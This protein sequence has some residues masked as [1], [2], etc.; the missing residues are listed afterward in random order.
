MLTP[1]VFEAKTKLIIEGLS[2]RKAW[3]LGYLSAGMTWILLTDRG[4]V[5]WTVTTPDPTTI[6]ALPEGVIVH[7]G[8]LRPIRFD[9]ESGSVPQ[10]APQQALMINGIPTLLFSDELWVAPNETDGR[11]GTWERSPVSEY[12]SRATSAVW[13]DGAEGNGDVWISHEGGISQWN[14]NEQTWRTPEALSRLVNSV[15]SKGPWPSGVGVW[16][17]Q[18]HLVQETDNRMIHVIADQ[19]KWTHESWRSD[20]PPV[21]VGEEVWGIRDGV[22]NGGVAGES[23]LEVS[24]PILATLRVNTM[25]SGDSKLWLLADQRLWRYSPAL[26]ADMEVEVGYAPITG[27]WIDGVDDGVGGLYLWGNSGLSLLTVERLPEWRLSTNTLGIDPITADLNNVDN[28]ETVIAQAWI[29]DRPVDEEQ[30]SIPEDSIDLLASNLSFYIERDTVTAAQVMLG[31]AWLVAYIEN[32]D[33]SSSLIQEQF[34]IQRPT[35]WS[36]N[37]EPLYQRS[38]QACHDGRGGARDLSDDILWA[39][40][41]EEIIFV[42]EMQSMPIGLPPFTEVEVDILRRW[43][44][45]G[46][47]Q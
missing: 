2:I 32:E 23:W 12:F 27:S 30:E 1:D 42:T 41:I 3:R 33:G 26:E 13:L 36:E 35:T 29:S 45:Y 19:S 18:A 10:E 38:C 21:F 34:S 28:D 9:T 17:W 25:W 43:R 37:V 31:E 46:F 47:V 15:L 8:E 20:V 14:A 11:V 40:A 44:D 5:S 6:Q 4:L 24:N 7:E 39:D 22:L 16:S